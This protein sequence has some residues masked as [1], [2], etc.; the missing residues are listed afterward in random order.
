[1]RKVEILRDEFGG[2]FNLAVN[3]AGVSVRMRLLGPQFD[4][5]EEHLSKTIGVN[6]TGAFN[7]SRFVSSLN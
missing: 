3:C 7:F 1:M 2:N 6:V 4:E 5:F